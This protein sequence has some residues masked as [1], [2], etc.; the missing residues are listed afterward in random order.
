VILVLD[1]VPGVVVAFG[2][3]LRRMSVPY[4]AAGT[5]AEAMALLPQHA[6]SAFIFDLELPDGSGIDLLE[7]ARSHPQWHDTPTA[8]ITASILLDDLTVLRIDATGA[9][10]HCGAFTGP[11]IEAILRELLSNR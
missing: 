7:W 6:W 9:T 3:L 11:D 10:L 2:G 5:V 1:D 8:V 4:H